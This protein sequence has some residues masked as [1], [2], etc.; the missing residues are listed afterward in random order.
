[1]LP[2][3]SCTHCRCGQETPPGTIPHFGVPFQS[4]NRILPVFREPVQFKRGKSKMSS[5]NKEDLKFVSERG[6]VLCFQLQRGVRGAADQGN[7]VPSYNVKTVY[8]VYPT[9]KGCPRWIL[10]VP[11]GVPCRIQWVLLCCDWIPSR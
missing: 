1:M 3:L 9:V 7:T 11:N 5:L 6:A 4:H 2:F 8:L 10:G